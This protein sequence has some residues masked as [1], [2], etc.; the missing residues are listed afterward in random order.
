MSELRDRLQNVFR[1]VFDD[2]DMVLRDAMTAD[3]VDG[4]DS[5]VHVDLMVAVE[6]EFG[7]KFA[8]GP[9]QKRGY[10]FEDSW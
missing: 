6:N 3:D 4:W 9:F 5:L 8:T 7:V 10:C 1:Q 2:P